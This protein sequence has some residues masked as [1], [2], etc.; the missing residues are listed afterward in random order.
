MSSINRGL[1]KEWLDRPVVIRYLGLFGSICLAVDAFLFGA[2]TFPRPH[3][4]FQ[5]VLTGHNGIAIIMLWLIGT[6]TLCAAWWFG[7]HLLG[8]AVI[9]AKWAL[10]TAVMWMVPMLVVPPTGS[11]DVYAYACQGAL[12]AGG[13]SPYVDGVSALPCPWL[14]SVSPIWRDT[15]APYGPVFLM[16]AGVASK[17]GSLVAAIVA[18]RLMAVIGVVIIAISLPPL[19]RRLGV[20][21]ERS[22][23]LVLACPLVSVHLIGGGHNDALTVGLLLAGLAVL[24]PAVDRRPRSRNALILGGILVGLSISVKTTIGV[25]LPFAALFAAGGPRLPEMRDLIRRAGTVMVAA[26]G[27]LLAFSFGSGLG[28]GWVTALSHAGDSIAW[29]SPPTA[30][31]LTVDYL[32]RPFGLDLHAVPVT[33]TIALVALPIALLAILWH[34]RNHN[35][36]YGAGLAML[37]TIFL[38]PITQP[39][40]L[41]WPLAMFAVTN[42]SARWLA[43]AIVVSMFTV[44]PDGSGINKLV[45]LPA[46]F[47]MTAL[48]GWTLVRAFTWLRGFEPNEIDFE[49]LRTPSDPEQP[50]LQV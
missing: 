41:M 13:H 26:L 2:F 11:R 40:Y 16:L 10:V 45:Q 47:A 14:E 31:G 50:V 29:T 25:A 27:T 18:F 22:L 4:T 21:V 17:L 1:I 12:Y 38:A 33:R 34:S 8:R 44:V 15:P 35:P 3:V 7:R 9:T 32:A 37:A 43:G 30:V 23:W 46:S 6:G 36:L 28:V 42:V 24:A 20:P 39:W 5:S 19:A 49:A 48:V